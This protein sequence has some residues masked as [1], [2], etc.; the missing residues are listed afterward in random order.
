MK[1]V[2]EGASKLDASYGIVNVRLAMALGDLGHEVTLSPWD[3]SVESCSQAI[4]HAYPSRADMV[5]STTDRSDAEVRIRQIW[6]PVWSRPR[7]DSRLVVI[8]PWEF[9]SIPLSWIEG[10]SG[11]DAIWVPSSF[12]KAGYVQSGVAPDKVWVVPNGADVES[13]LRPQRSRRAGQMLSLLFVGGGIYRKGIDVLVAA[14]DSLDDDTLAR[15]RLTIKETG[16]SSYYAGQSLVESALNGAPR[17]A[18][19]TVV[20]RE[21]LT[22]AQLGELY[23]SADCLV[24]PYRSEGFALPVLESMSSGLPVVV[25]RDGAADDFCGDGEATRIDSTLTVSDT[26][27]VGDILTADYPY[28][29]EPSASHLSSIIKQ[30]V[31]C[32]ID[33]EPLRRAAFARASEYQWERVGAV[34]GRSLVALVA[35]IGPEDAFGTAAVEVRRFVADQDHGRWVPVV[36]ALLAVGDRKGALRVMEIAAA[37]SR[38]DATLVQILSQL[39]AAASALPD[40]W[41]GATWRLDLAAALR[42]HGDAPLV[43]HRSDRDHAAVTVIAGVIAPYF[44]SCKHVLDLGCGLGA[45]MR[46]LRAAGKKV[47][48]IEGDPEVVDNLRA[49]GF[50]VEQG[51]IPRDL[52]KLSD[53]RFDGVFMGHIVEHLST[54]QALEV[55]RWVAD[56]IAD[57][58][59]IV[60]QT[61]DLAND[62]VCKTNFWL[63]PTHVRPY[64]VSLL[65]SM[66]ESSGFAPLAG[67]C[68][69]LAPHAPLDV[70]AVGRLHKLPAA[71]LRH[72][73]SL[74]PR[75]ARRVLHFGMF[76]SQSGMGHASR[77]LL[78]P[79][80][81]ESEGVDVVRIELGD[82]SDGRFPPGTHTLSESL[83][84]P[85]DI[86]VIDVPI[87]WLPNL[88]PWVRARHHIVRLAFEARPLPR[89]IVD[90]LR[91]V[92]EIW[93]MSEFV[94][95]VATQSG[96]DRDRL[97]VIPPAV[98]VRADAESVFSGT[99]NGA[100]PSIYSSVFNFEPRKN[101]EA[102]L[103]AYL[104]VLHSGRDVRLVLKTSGIDDA[105]FW[106]WAA[107]VVGSE[108]LEELR[109]SCDLVTASLDDAALQDLLR[110]SDAFVL[111]TRG[112]GFGLP[113]LEAMAVGVP[114]I[115]PD[116]GGHRDFC[117]GE[118]SFLVPTREVPCA[119]KWNI[120]LFRESSWYEVDQEELI[121]AMERIV[122]EPET[123]VKKAALSLMRARDMAA[124]DQRS[125]AAARIVSLIDS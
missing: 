91:G 48:G 41:S 109:E 23:G 95:K 24:H 86:A 114:V 100:R 7:D 2:V 118:T 11:A 107:T 56:H 99:S 98:P 73:T 45:M 87:G 120:P 16:Y 35:R 101:P 54:E 37:R 38:T 60:V 104:S 115:C 25:T 94:E 110:H 81:S 123:V 82:E 52:D 1:I 84:L 27:Y 85:A 103:R 33:V 14:L 74:R 17:V 108:G 19:R 116:R 40:L 13:S 8:Q 66:L 9:G 92:A 119:A 20:R 71:P 70:I 21:H 72:G 102:L 53:V 61:P 15:V 88:L 49:E 44:S 18:S 64:P 90:A 10:A 65:T 34:A 4:A 67:G 117:D 89:Y 78:D 36:A 96:L 58:G 31:D 76:R 83:D 47:T 30:L 105:S 68:R 51:W 43:V 57:G 12:V 79:S 77:A 121:D 111:P 42:E 26:P 62:L 80:M 69:S 3:Q 29:R 32:E 113:F 22:P 28:H 122:D 5:V 59:T 75:P 97:V 106:Q 125:V 124:I 63:D 50:S 46:T 55:L 6:P 39:R 112:E 93:P